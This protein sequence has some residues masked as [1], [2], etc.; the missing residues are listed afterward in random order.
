MD[1][2]FSKVLS[3]PSSSGVKS[4]PASSIGLKYEISV[5]FKKEFCRCPRMLFW[6]SYQ[7]PNMCCLSSM[8]SQVPGLSPF[9][10]CLSLFLPSQTV[11]PEL[12]RK[13]DPMDGKCKVFRRVA[14]CWDWRTSAQFMTS[15]TE[16][17]CLS[18]LWNIIFRY[19]KMIFFEIIK[20]INVFTFSKNTAGI[21]RE[22]LK[23]EQRSLYSQLLLEL[24]V[25]SS[26]LV[27]MWGNIWELVI[28]FFTSLFTFILDLMTSSSSSIHFS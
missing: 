3:N 21:P 18:D 11:V 4:L 7:L 10:F 13:N 2:D 26:I 25:S 19:L 15:F 8:K 23:L 27:N 14:C 16:T 22:F 9:L 12:E 24:I 6:K 17:N 20:H 28:E 5:I 1:L